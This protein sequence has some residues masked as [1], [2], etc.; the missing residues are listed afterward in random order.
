MFNRIDLTDLRVLI[1]GASSGIGA[2]LA[3][4]LAGARARLVLAARVPEPLEALGRELRSTGA[5][6]VTVPA[7]VTVA[8]D[9]KR[10]IEEAVTAFGGVDVLVNN[11][12]IGATGSFADASE[13]RLRRIFE[14]NFFGAAELTRLAIPLLRQGRSPAIVNIA[15]IVGRR[16]VPGYSEY[17]ASKFA[18]IGWSE[19]LRAELARDGIHV[20]IA[21]PGPTQ[22][23]FNSRMLEDRLAPQQ[24][25]MMPA[26]Q[27]AAL[28]VRA[29]RQ[30]R[31]EVAMT[32]QGR[33]LLQLNR[34][35]PRLVD[36]VMAR[37]FARATGKP[38][39]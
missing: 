19:A 20:L 2:A 24:F 23:D 11:A 32:F 25:K 22:T 29:L 10:L 8:A 35:M 26:D 9:R 3:R 31:N 4:A 37:D 15:S 14:V 30:R 5:Q 27:C 36:R 7:D 1:T 39:V 6:V 38:Q 18:L 13:E 16:G 17:G 21:C 34:W 28:I 12:G 33:L